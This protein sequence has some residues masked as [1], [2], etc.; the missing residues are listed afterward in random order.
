MTVI[1]DPET[2]LIHRVDGRITMGSRE[3]IMGVVYGDYRRVVD[4]MLPHRII[5]Y[6]NGAAIAESLYDSVIVNAGAKMQYNLYRK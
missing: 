6:V 2:G 3:V 1:I 4:I 5:N